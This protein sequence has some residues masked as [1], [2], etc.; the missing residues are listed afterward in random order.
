M[1]LL[2]LIGL[3]LAFVLSVHSCLG[4]VG[5]LDCSEEYHFWIIRKRFSFNSLNH[6]QL[7]RCNRNYPAAAF[8]VFDAFVFSNRF[9]V[10]VCLL[11]SL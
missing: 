5:R 6:R 1:L 11:F 9:N 4:I 7:E 8:I 2:F 10:V 3:V